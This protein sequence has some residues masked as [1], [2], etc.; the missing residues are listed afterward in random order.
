[1]LG[2]VRDR[3]RPGGMFYGW[4]IV[5]AGAVSIAG[6]TGITVLGFSLFVGPV[7]DELGWSVT[8][9]SIG[10]SIRSFEQGLLS[11][12][13]GN[14]LDRFGPR[15]MA[16]IGICTTAVG[17]AL[18]SQIQEVWHYYVASMVLAVGQSL[19]AGGNPFTLAVMQWFSRKRGRAAGLMNL[20]NGSGYLVVP[21]IAILLAAFGWRETLLIL[22]GA[23]LV[24]LLPLAMVLRWGPERY[25]LLPDGERA[26]P[27]GDEVAAANAPVRAMMSGSGMSVGEALR[28]RAFFC[29][30]LAGVASGASFNTWNVHLV[31]HLTNQGFS[32]S[33]ASLFIAA[34]GLIS[35]AARVSVGWFGDRLGRHNV[36]MLAFLFL[37]LGYALFA[38]LSPD[39][40]YLL[41]IYF[42]ANTTG[43]AGFSVLGQTMVADYFGTRRFGTIRG[44]NGTLAMPF[45]I[46][47]PI[48][49]GWMFDHYGDYQ[50]AFVIVGAVAASGF[51]W[52]LLAGKPAMHER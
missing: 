16:I 33:T 5:M 22:A 3:Q 23:V 6:A 28:T 37:G 30:M 20:G 32:T 29:L 38:F 42:L 19:G 17:L 24:I 45:G 31:P 13:T 46:G 4:Y 27:D 34:F 7:R 43:M 26:E 1:M 9:I 41:P 8:V 2:R 52:V 36:Y 40:P 12:F 35:L 48:L 15:R 11:P 51:L 18:F 14:L 47:M 25:G 39:R 44:L 50:L 49:A 10:Y 21:L